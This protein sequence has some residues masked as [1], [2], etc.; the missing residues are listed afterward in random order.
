MKSISSS[1]P[2]TLA[3]KWFF[4][5]E[6]PQSML[7]FLHLRKKKQISHWYRKGPQRILQTAPRIRTQSV[8]QRES[9]PLI[10]RQSNVYYI[11]YF[12]AAPGSNVKYQVCVCKVFSSPAASSHICHGSRQSNFLH[13]PTWGPRP[14]VALLLWP[15]QRRKCFQLIE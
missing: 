9:V 3:S 8:S 11:S 15:N 2:L 6:W 7:I 4:W 14:F 12:G 1:N 5:K 10:A 13:V